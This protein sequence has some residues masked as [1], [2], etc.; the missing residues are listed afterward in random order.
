MSDGCAALLTHLWEGVVAATG[1]GLSV[2]PE[3]FAHW[4]L[5]AW[6][7]RR[8]VL[9]ILLTAVGGVLPRV[10]CCGVIGRILAE[11]TEAAYRGSTDEDLADDEQPSSNCSSIERMEA[12]ATHVAWHTS[13]S[14]ETRSAEA[15]RSPLCNSSAISAPASVPGTAG[16]PIPAGMTPVRPG[17]AACDRPSVRGVLMIRGSYGHLRDRVVSAVLR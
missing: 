4:G 7:V 17:E 10:R 16:S 15:V 12:P 14:A 3:R 6:E 1:T 11:A 2:D 13:V 8:V 9:A 5:D